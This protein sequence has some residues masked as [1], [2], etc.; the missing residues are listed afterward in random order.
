MSDLIYSLL[1]RMPDGGTAHLT[2]DITV[3]PDAP[4]RTVQEPI[5]GGWAA[6]HGY[7]LDPA[8]TEVIGWELTPA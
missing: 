6:E 7:N 3:G 8:T 4:T 1:I 2:D 5:I